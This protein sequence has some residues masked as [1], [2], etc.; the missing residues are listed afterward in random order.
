M[1]VNSFRPPAASTKSSRLSRSKRVGGVLA[2]GL[3]M[4]AAVGINPGVATAD[5]VLAPGQHLSLSAQCTAQTG[6][7]FAQCDAV[8]PGG[9]T[10]VVCQSE[11]G[12]RYTVT[13]SG[14]KEGED[15]EGSTGSTIRACAQVYPKIRKGP[16]D[17]V[18]LRC[19]ADSE[20]GP[21][22]FNG[23]LSFGDQAILR[24]SLNGTNWQTASV[25]ADVDG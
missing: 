6:T 11:G 7:A 21:S 20:Y 22:A 3:G 25:Q 24:A 17:K 18:V 14:Q 10:K 9:G 16:Y 4:M 23:T 8:S 19:S 5:E 2:V 15:W 13:A 12:C 1:V